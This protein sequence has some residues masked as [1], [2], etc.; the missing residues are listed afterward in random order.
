VA[1]GVITDHWSAVSPTGVLD[2]FV[3]RTPDERL[4][5]PDEPVH[6]PVPAAVVAQPAI[7]APVEPIEPPAETPRAIDAPLMPSAPPPVAP[8][9]PDPPRAPRTN[10]NVVLLPSN[11]PDDPGPH[12]MPDRKPG[13]RLY[14]NE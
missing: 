6:Q 5:A 14:A 4:S 1:E 2:A 7:E 13:Y 8:S 12:D 3:W 9:S 11:A 10:G